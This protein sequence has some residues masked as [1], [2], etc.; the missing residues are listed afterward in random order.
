MASIVQNI[1]HFD[2]AFGGLNAFC[3]MLFCLLYVPCVATMATIKKK[4]RFLEVHRQYHAFP[5]WPGLAGKRSLY[6]DRQF[7]HRKDGGVL[8]YPPMDYRV[9]HFF[10][11]L[12]C[13][14]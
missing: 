11:A 13:I 5:D 12:P 8:M 6:S 4:K 1:Q 9:K 3:L 7:F 14:Y 10:L 2:P